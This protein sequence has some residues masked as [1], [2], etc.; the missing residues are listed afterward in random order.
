MILILLRPFLTLLAEH[1]KILY[2][3]K[4]VILPIN[5][6]IILEYHHLLN[7]N[8]YTI[9]P[10]NIFTYFS[11]N[12]PHKIHIYFIFPLLWI[13]FITAKYITKILIFIKNLAN[14]IKFPHL[15]NSKFLYISPLFLYITIRTPIS[16]IFFY[17]IRL[18]SIHHQLFFY[19]TIPSRKITYHKKFYSQK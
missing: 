11:K 3:F 12:F 8:L 2:L 9:F 4:P 15:K 16:S 14:P 1:L 17:K 19:Y 18:H 6:I 10:L 5:D 7:L 13:L